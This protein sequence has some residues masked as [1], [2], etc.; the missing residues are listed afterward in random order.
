MG[1]L[2]QKDVCIPKFLEMHSSEL[3]EI[4][5]EQYFG[6]L[7]INSGE[8]FGIQTSFCAIIRETFGIQ[9]SFCAIL[10]RHPPRPLKHTIMHGA[11]LTSNQS[12]FNVLIISELPIDFSYIT[13][14]FSQALDVIFSRLKP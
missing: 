13:N 12:I 4:Y 3:N 10:I 5:E 8:T 14:A 2:A 9:T 1:V 11:R 6:Y 7:S